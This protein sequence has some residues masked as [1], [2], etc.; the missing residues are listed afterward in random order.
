MARPA[1]STTPYNSSTGVTTL[2]GDTN[3]DG[4]ADFA[5]D[6]TG[7]ISISLADL[8]GF[9]RRRHRRGIREHQP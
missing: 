4:V 7:N 1:N 6:L 3:G 2:Q 9:T 8:I 5:I